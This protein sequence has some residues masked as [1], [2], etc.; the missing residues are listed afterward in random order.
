M[1]EEQFV[2]IDLNDDNVCCV[3]QTETE[4]EMLSFCHL[5]FELSIEGISRSTLLHTQSLKGHRDC[6]EKCHLIAN[7]DLPRPK[8][9]RSTYRDMKDVL[10]R[11]ISRSCS[12]P[13]ISG[14]RLTSSRTAPE[15]R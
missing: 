4:T 11:R 1:N 3:C 7:Q 10:S 13:R 9:S 15:S 14:W 2:N 6:F 5:C 12:T 8:V